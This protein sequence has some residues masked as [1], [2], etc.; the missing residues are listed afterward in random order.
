MKGFLFVV[1][2]HSLRAWKLAF[3]FEVVYRKDC[4]YISGSFDLRK[5]SCSTSKDGGGGK[6]QKSSA[7]QISSLVF[8]LAQTPTG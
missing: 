5:S 1:S 4:K 6:S 2:C 8:D 7:A 3:L